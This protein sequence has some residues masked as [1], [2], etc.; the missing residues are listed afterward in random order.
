MALMDAVLR[1]RPPGVLGNSS[2]ADDD[3]FADGLLDEPCYTRPA[4]FEGRTVPR[5][6]LSGNHEAILRWRRRRSLIITA[7]RRPDLIK[8]NIS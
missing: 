1:H 2:S 5:T 7:R 4:V 6:L 3:S 8:K